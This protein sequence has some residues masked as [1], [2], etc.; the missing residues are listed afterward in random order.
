[1]LALIAVGVL[2]V[3][4]GVAWAVSSNGPYYAMPAW[5]QKLAAAPRFVVLLD[6]NSQAVLDRNTGLVWE[7]APA[8][9]LQ[10]WQS[11]S[12]NCINKN[13]GGRKGWRLPSMPELASL[14]DPSVAIPGPTLPPGHPFTIVQPAENVGKEYWSASTEA[15]FPLGAWAVGFLGGGVNGFNKTATFSAWCVRGGMNADAY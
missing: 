12:L 2:A 10:N 7:Q 1:M 9:T 8:A 13:V 5:D 15:D 11:A 3:A 14:V 4:V 6:W